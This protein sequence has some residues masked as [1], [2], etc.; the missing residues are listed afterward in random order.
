MQRKRCTVLM[1]TLAI[2]FTGSACA[3]SPS[4]QLAAKPAD[5]PTLVSTACGEFIDP[6]AFSGLLVYLAADGGYEPITDATFWRDSLTGG[7]PQL[8]AVDIQ[9]DGTFTARVGIHAS[10]ST[11]TRGST[12]V[13]TEGWVED[14]AFNIRAQGCEPLVVHFAMDWKPRELLM[15]CPGRV[16]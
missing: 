3:T 13:K 7:A 1:A 9:A 4:P 2:V 16:P 12:I 8:Q 14:V 15:Q 6:P 10:G 5:E 11:S